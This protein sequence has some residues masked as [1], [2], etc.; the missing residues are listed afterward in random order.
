[1]TDSTSTPNTWG[2]RL[3]AVCAF[4]VHV[5]AITGMFDQMTAWLLRNS[6]WEIAGMS[7]YILVLA[8]VESALVYLFAGLAARLASR[9]I[10]RKTLPATMILYWA[11]SLLVMAADL[12]ESLFTSLWLILIVGLFLLVVAAGLWAVFRFERFAAGLTAFSERLVVL[13]LIYFA[14]DALGL[15]VVV[16]RNL[17]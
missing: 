1:M 10:D 6:L 7:G 4:P 17:G 16:L 11:F 9:F 12:R 14:F 5:W 3:F 2:L 13:T 15:L 8:L